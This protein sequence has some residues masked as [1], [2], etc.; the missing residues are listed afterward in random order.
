M[1]DVD[2]STEMV[3]LA[4]SGDKAS[5][6]YDIVFTAA[7]EAEGIVTVDALA[8]S[9]DANCVVLAVVTQPADLARMPRHDGPVV[10]RLTSAVHVCR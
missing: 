9:P 2:F 5:S 7:S 6:G 3:V 8:T 4:A 10:F 1:P